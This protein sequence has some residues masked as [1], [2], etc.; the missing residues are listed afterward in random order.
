MTKESLAFILAKVVGKLEPS[1][2]I[3]SL[4]NLALGL[5]S[6]TGSIVETSSFLF[7]LSQKHEE[8]QCW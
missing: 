8:I 6:A 7:I 2:P 5:L 4:A 3:E 1:V